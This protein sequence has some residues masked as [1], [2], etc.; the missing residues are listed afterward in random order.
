MQLPVLCTLLVK[1]KGVVSYLSL[2]CGTVASLWIQNSSCNGKAFHTVINI[3]GKTLL[4]YQTN[5]FTISSRCSWCE[6][7]VTVHYRLLLLSCAVLLLHLPPHSTPPH[8]HPR[9]HELK[10]PLVLKDKAFSSIL[11]L[12]SDLI[13]PLLLLGHKRPPPPSYYH[14]SS[15]SHVFIIII[16]SAVFVCLSLSFPAEIEAENRPSHVCCITP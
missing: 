2:F 8:P 1:E 12:P 9:D 4:F 10:F 16:T 5:I 11:S 3:W 15:L 7:C 13:F 14:V 6:P